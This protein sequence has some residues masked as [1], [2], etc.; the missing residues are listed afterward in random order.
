MGDSDTSFCLSS[1]L[2]FENETCFNQEQDD[3]NKY[4]DYYLC[5]D[6][7][8]E[9]AYVENLFKKETSFGSKPSVSSDDCDN[10]TQNW[11][12]SVRLDAIEWIF[13]VGNSI[14]NY[15]NDSSFICLGSFV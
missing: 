8:N 11:L 6:S 5:F 14:Q 15:N 9:D 1:L 4:I 2:C 7:E 3:E 13:K 12:K 10:I